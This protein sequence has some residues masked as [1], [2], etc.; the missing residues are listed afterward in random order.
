CDQV[1]TVSGIPACGA[2]RAGNATH[3]TPK[4][5]GGFMN[6]SA[7]PLRRIDPEKFRDP[8]VTATGEAR[9]TVTLQSLD[10][11]WINTGTLCTLT[12]RNCYIDSSPRNDRLV[13][14]AAAE[15]G[16]YLDEIDREELGTQLIGFTGGEPFMNPELPAMLEDALSRG[17]EV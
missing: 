13:Y 2:G 11:L 1:A 16:A 12:C 17:F 7:Q 3:H 8:E 9:A 14:I 6:A 10:T 15:A 4:H 5:S